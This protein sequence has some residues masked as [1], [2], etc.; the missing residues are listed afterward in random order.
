MEPR[1]M[2]KTHLLQKKSQKVKKIIHS[3]WHEVWFK[4]NSDVDFD[5]TPIPTRR[6]DFAHHCI[7]AVTPKFPPGYAPDFF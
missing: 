3:R 2:K 1:K 4:T 7:G 5:F 6:A